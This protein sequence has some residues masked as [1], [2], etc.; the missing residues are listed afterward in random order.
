MAKTPAA[1]SPMETADT[2][3]PVGVAAM[4]HVAYTRPFRRCQQLALDAFERARAAGKR[5]TDLVLPP[6][7]GKTALGLEAIR[8]SG[9][10]SRVRVRGPGRDGRHWIDARSGRRGGG[11]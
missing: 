10:H 7:E 6:G 4:R 9:G 2:H 1:E 3:L 5:R 11:T 8:R